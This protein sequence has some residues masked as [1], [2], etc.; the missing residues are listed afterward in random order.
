[1]IRIIF[2]LSVVSLTSFAGDVSKKKSAD[3]PKPKDCVEE[4]MLSARMI[5]H[6]EN[7]KVDGFAFKDVQE[8]SVWQKWGVKNDDVMIAVSGKQTIDPLG[9][10]G[11]TREICSL[12]GTMTVKRAG[13]EVVLKAGK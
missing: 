6:F 1:M 13:K 5:P 2:V 12:K 10:L 4:A 7:G 8:K 11:A 9:A 3:A